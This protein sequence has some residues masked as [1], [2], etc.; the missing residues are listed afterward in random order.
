MTSSTSSL[1]QMKQEGS[2]VTACML[3]DANDGDHDAMMMVMSL[4]N[5]LIME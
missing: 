3:Y 4:I 5:A 1:Y 2:Q